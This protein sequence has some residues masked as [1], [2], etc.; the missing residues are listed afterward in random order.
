MAITP[1]IL[2]PLLLLLLAVAVAGSREFNHLGRRIADKRGLAIPVPKVCCAID[3]SRCSE[4]RRLDLRKWMRS[5]GK[6]NGWP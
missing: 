5:I 3:S 4:T 1:R 6:W 2:V